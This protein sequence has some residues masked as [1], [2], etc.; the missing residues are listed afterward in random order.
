[1]KTIPSKTDNSISELKNALRSFDFC[2]WTDAVCCIMLISGILY[3]PFVFTLSLIMMTVRILFIGNRKNKLNNIKNSLPVLLCLTSVYL[4]NIIGML[5]TQNIAGGLFELNHKLPFLIIPLFFAATA[6]LKPQGVRLVTAFYIAA[7]LIGILWGFIHYM[8]NPYA[9][10][11]LLIPTARNISFALNICFAV[12]IMA[13]HTV[14]NKRFNIC[15]ALLIALFCLYLFT[16]QLVSGIITL[17]ISAALGVVILLR[18]FNKTLSALVIALSLI[19][20]CAG[21]YWIYRQYNNY[22]TPKENLYASVGQLTAKGNRYIESKSKFIENGYYVASYCCP[23][24]IAEAWKELTGMDADEYCEG[25]LG[26]EN[27]K[28]HK[29]LLRYL[30]SKGLKK[31]Y[32]G[33]MSLNEKDILNIKKGYS[34]YIYAQRFSLKPRLYQT[35]YEFERYF[36]THEVDDMSVIQRYFWSKN[37][38][39]VIKQHILI[40]TGTGDTKDELVKPVIKTHPELCT[41]FCNPHNQFIYSMAAFGILGLIVML[42]Y[43]FYLPVKMKLFYNGTFLAFFIIALCWMFAESSFESYEGMTFISSFMSFFCLNRKYVQQ[44]HD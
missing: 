33:V 17:L 16:A 22:F 44:N 2:D 20:V 32:N 38:F 11:R 35:F 29:I 26:N 36:R 39:S 28:Y 37:A 19:A 1:M 8:V 3:S 27:Y 41:T 40:G 6:G 21:G 10:T 23:Q 12:S 4:L 9:N 34:N 25:R 30:N 24:E 15:T 31:D 14:R 43:V 5:W 42:I 7:L 18:Q 13:V